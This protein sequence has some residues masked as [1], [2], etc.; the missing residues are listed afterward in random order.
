MNNVILRF[1][2]MFLT[3][4]FGLASNALINDLGSLVERWIENPE[5][6]LEEPSINFLVAPPGEIPWDWDRNCGLLVVNVG[7]NRSLRLNGEDMGSLENTSELVARLNEVFTR[8]TEARAYRERLELN[9][10]VTAEGRIERTVI[11]WAP[12][13]LS[14]GELSDLIDEIRATGATPIGLATAGRWVRPIQV[15]PEGI[16]SSLGRTR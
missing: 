15:R 3:F 8:R 6:L 16:T 12:R 1:G 11:I 7:Y 14:Y 2:T 9:S 5:P 13:W 4:T 10:D